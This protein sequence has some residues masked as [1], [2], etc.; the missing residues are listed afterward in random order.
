MELAARRR[1]RVVYFVNNHGS[2]YGGHW[3]NWERDHWQHW[4][5]VQLKAS[6]EHACQ[7]THDDAKW[8]GKTNLFLTFLHAYSAYKKGWTLL[9]KKKKKRPKFQ[10][11]TS[12]HFFSF[13]R[14]KMSVSTEILIW[15]FHALLCLRVVDS[16]KKAALKAEQL[17]QRCIDAQYETYKDDFELWVMQSHF[18]RIY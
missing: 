6:T 13:W 18:C 7:L 12:A 17:K 3:A 8:L 15:S 4:P 11:L 1:L 2:D 10:V 14:W 9:Y 16:Q 5:F